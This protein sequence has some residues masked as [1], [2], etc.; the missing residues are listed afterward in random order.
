MLFCTLPGIYGAAVQP[1]PRTSR[2]SRGGAAAQIQR[3][4]MVYWS[5]RRQC[6]ARDERGSTSIEYALIAALCSVAIVAGLHGIRDGI[7]THLNDAAGGLRTGL[8]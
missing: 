5:T 4:P 1:Q 6:F 2:K 8:N 7:T 3:W